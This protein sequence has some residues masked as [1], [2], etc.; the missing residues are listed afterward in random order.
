V[1]EGTGWLMAADGRYKLIASPVEPLWLID[2]K[3]DPAEL[4]N[5]AGDPALHE[6]RKLMAA[7]LLNYA[8][9]YNDPNLN[10]GNGKLRRSLE[11]AL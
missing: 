5:R 11:A 9:K 2:L 1:R 7:A 3:E 10:L 6:R 4:V 8:E